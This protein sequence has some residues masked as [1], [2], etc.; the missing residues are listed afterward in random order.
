MN[1]Q[2]IMT[3]LDSLR[4]RDPHGSADPRLLDA[5]D[6]GYRRWGRL[7]RHGRTLAAILALAL[8]TAAT[9]VAVPAPHYNYVLGAM[10]SRPNVACTQIYSILDLS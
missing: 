10:A 7:M 2:E 5:M 1:E 9:A 4:P 3:L 6:S 8:I